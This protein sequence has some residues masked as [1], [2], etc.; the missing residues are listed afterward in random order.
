MRTRNLSHTH[1]HT[2]THVQG[3]FPYPKAWYSNFMMNVFGEFVRTGNIYY[4]ELG[5]GL[6]F[7]RNG[8]EIL[9]ETYLA[10][11]SQCAMWD[12]P[13]FTNTGQKYFNFASFCSG[14]TGVSS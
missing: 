9:D 8:V 12:D 13:S 11:E 10:S 3:Q 5:A 2:H 1:T 14:M 7:T 4:D 6:A